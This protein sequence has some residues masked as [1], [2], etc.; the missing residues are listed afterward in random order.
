MFATPT[1]T[2]TSLL[3]F[4]SRRNGQDWRSIGYLYISDPIGDSGSNSRVG[5]VFLFFSRAF[6]L[7]GGQRGSVSQ[8][9]VDSGLILQDRVTRIGKEPRRERL[10]GRRVARHAMREE[11]RIRA[12]H[13]FLTGEIDRDTYR[14]YVAGVMRHKP[15]RHSAK[16]IVEVDPGA[17]VAA[18]GS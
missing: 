13:P 17:D 9:L 7:L 18:S 11:R 3:S 6:E 16:D 14:R 8:D 1:T 4:L 2:R 15:K 10:T 12:S 5:I